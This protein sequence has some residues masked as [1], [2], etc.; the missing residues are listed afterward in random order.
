MIYMCRRS[1]PYTFNRSITVSQQ[2]T[3]QRQYSV[4]DLSVLETVKTI[5]VCESNLE[6]HSK[7]NSLSPYPNTLQNYYTA[8]ALEMELIQS[9]V[10]SE[11]CD[12]GEGGGD[13]LIGTGN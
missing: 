1:K 10:M 9:S 13:Q 8:S 7:G 12:G 11:G 3:T 4:E 5:P 6:A 2:E